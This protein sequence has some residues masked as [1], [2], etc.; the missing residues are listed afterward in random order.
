[1]EVIKRK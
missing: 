1:M